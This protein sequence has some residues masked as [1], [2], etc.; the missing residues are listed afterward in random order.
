MK[1][2]IR[3]KS[4]MNIAG[5]ALVSVILAACAAPS[6]RTMFDYS[7]VGP[8]KAA[9]AYARL[10]R[11]GSKADLVVRVCDVGPDGVARSCKDTLVLAD[12]AKDMTTGPGSRR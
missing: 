9:T 1:I 4:V 8:D 5:L 6:P 10:A 12:L 7:Y 2:L 11:V 3:E